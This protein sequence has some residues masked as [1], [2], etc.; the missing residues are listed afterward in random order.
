MKGQPADFGALVRT[1]LSSFIE[2][3]GSPLTMGVEE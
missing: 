3:G 2:I 1:G